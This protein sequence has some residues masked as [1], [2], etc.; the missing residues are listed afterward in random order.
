MMKEE[1]GKGKE[2]KGKRKRERGK[3]KQGKL[4]PIGYPDSCTGWDWRLY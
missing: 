4:L 2:E 1:R 3:R